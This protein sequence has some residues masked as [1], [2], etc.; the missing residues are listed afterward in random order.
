[1]AA[2]TKTSAGHD[3]KRPNSIRQWHRVRAAKDASRAIP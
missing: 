2:R 1:M 3:F